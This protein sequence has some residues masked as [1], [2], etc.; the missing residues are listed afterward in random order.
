MLG[1]AATR[2]ELNRDSDIEE[3]EQEKARRIQELERQNLRPIRYRMGGGSRH[4]GTDGTPLN[5]NS[6]MMHS[7]FTN[8]S[9]SSGQ[10]GV[11]SNLLQM[12]N[13]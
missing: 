5:N 1:R 8:E 11:N 6:A 12:P 4:G 7:I 13:F 9:S 2:I 3:L 10:I